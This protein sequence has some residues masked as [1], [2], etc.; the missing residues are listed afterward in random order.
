MANSLSSDTTASGAG[1]ADG[2]NSEDKQE[3]NAVEEATLENLDGAQWGDDEEPIDI[4]M[5]EDLA[6]TTEDGVEG[7]AAEGTQ[8]GDVFV[9]PAHG[10]NP[11]Q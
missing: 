5:G 8:D 3:K 1:A 9:P 7:K 11:I 2:S 4:D 6:A 10:A